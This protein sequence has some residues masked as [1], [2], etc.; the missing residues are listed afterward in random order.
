MR[1]KKLVYS[2]ENFRVFE[3]FGNGPICTEVFN[4]GE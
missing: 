4:Y 3:G 1:V 2:I